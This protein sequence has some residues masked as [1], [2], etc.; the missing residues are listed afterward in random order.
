MQKQRRIDEFEFGTIVIDDQAYSEDVI[1]FPD[2]KIKRWQPKDGHILR[3]RDVKA[4]IKT[5]PEVVIIG[6]GAV[7]NLAVR[8][9][10]DKRLQKAGIE[11]LTYRTSK[12]CDTYREF[13]TQRRVAAILHLT[14]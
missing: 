11:V 1:I 8:P 3:P 7:G 13:R 5:K 9:K 2:G 14:S 12:A 6:T 4:V 10:A